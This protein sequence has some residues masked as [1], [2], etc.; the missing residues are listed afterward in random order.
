M[1]ITVLKMAQRAKTAA[2]HLGALNTTTKNAALK[3]MAEA[4]LANMP[5]IKDAN[6]T[7]L[8]SGRASGLSDTLLDRLTLNDARIRSMAEGL[9]QVAALPDPVGQGSSGARL[10][11][12]LEMQRVRVPL[13]VVGH[14][15]KPSSPPQCDRRC[16]QSVSE[17]G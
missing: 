4:L 7:D 17:G 15:L 8:V 14:H 10:A 2:R 9:Q 11:N 16:R 12:G 3:A 1:M 5:Q 13:G 6:G